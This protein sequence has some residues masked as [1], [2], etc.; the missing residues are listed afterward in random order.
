M[1]ATLFTQNAQSNSPNAI[2]EGLVGVDVG[3]YGS[4]FSGYTPPA[5]V[6]DTVTTDI[7]LVINTN[8][9][10]PAKRLYVYGNGA[11]SYAA[12]T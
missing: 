3:Y 1:K 10:T 5:V 9:T 8:A 6:D 12:L 11:W 2:V 7:R 4:T